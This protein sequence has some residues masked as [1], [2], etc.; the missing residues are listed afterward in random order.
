MAL[1]TIEGLN[2]SVT[3]GADLD[4]W[5][6]KEDVFSATVNYTTVETTG[7][8]DAGAET[9]AHTKVG[10]SGTITGTGQSGA[11][12]SAA[13]PTTAIALGTEDPAG[14]LTLQYNTGCTLAFTAL[15]TSIATTRAHDGKM[16][17]TQSF[18]SSGAITTAWVEA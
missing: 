7:F 17:I 2:A 1:G 15:Y 14:P 10:V 13:F 8:D 11:A 3:R 18:I 4:E 16:E 5:N 12:S 9:H 6:L